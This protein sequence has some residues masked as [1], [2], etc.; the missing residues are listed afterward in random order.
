MANYRLND[1]D[2]QAAINAYAEHDGNQVQAAK[3]LNLP[4]AT[5][6]T[7]LREAQRNGFKP[8][9]KTKGNP[10]D[11][12]VLRGRVKR[13]EDELR[14]YERQTGHD[15]VIEGLIGGLVEKVRNYDPP[16]WT[17]SAARP[18]GSPGVPTLF[19]SDLHWGEVVFPSQ[20]N[21]VNEYNL[22][23][24]KKRLRKAVERAIHLL[25]IIDPKMN[26]PG[27]VLPL[28]GDMISGDLHDE[29]TATN[30]LP[31]IPA[32]VD[33]FG[34]LVQTVKILA[35][36][37]G[38][39]FLPCVTGN[40][41][42]NTRKIW[43]KSRHHTS[44][45]WMLYQFLAK[46]FIGDKRITFFVPD[47]I[48]AHYKIYGHRYRL[49]HGDKLGKGGD[50]IIGAIGPII[51]GDQRT[52]SRDAQID[53]GYDTQI[54]GHWHQYMHLTRVI[55]NGS[56]KGYDEYANVEGFPFEEPQQALWLTHP[57]N[58]ITYRM[59]VFVGEKQQ[60]AE[61]SWVSVPK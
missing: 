58:G 37:F 7:R 20:I 33:L 54:I 52:R 31:S 2:Y 5:F 3:S 22:R 23:I 6:Q 19:L 26:Y 4:R 11:P 28:G 36:Q 61:T 18:A 47:G 38:A 9:G 57:R 50:G 34:E 43:A 53:L 44:F 55:V 56:L 8:G 40:H 17:L 21:D 46:H 45:D 29:L 10:D 24:A 25:G 15:K 14:I 48:A 49:S 30:E 16:E 32:V 35:E 59:P 39:V 12:Q 60:A 51:R 1:T 13:L 42:K 27:I 41:G